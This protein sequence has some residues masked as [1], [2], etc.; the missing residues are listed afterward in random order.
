[1]WAQLITMRLREGHDGDV[2]AIFDSLAASEVPGS[3]LVRN[4]TMRDQADP[5]RIYTL[6]V[7]ES[8]EKARERERDPRREAALVEVR[9]LMAEA[10]DG[11]PEF[12][13][14]EVVGEHVA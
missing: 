12:V 14:L 13:N 10:F 7:F 5:S 8:E 6:V 3:G 9:R 2:S 1:M 11:P 4:V